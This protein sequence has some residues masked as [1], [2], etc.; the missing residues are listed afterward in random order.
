MS[1]ELTDYFSISMSVISQPHK[2]VVPRK[3]PGTTPV[4]R[5]EVCHLKD[6]GK[7]L[8]IYLIGTTITVEWKSLD[9]VI[10]G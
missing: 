10:G 1:K 9:V 6:F 3:P 2:H 4:K 7:K 8:M 5:F